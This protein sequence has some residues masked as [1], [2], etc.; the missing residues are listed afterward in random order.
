MTAYDDAVLADN[1][2]GYWVQ[3]ETGGTTLADASGGGHT[4]AITGAPTFAQPGPDG[5]PNAI[6]WPASSSVFAE[7][8]IVGDRYWTFEVWIYLTEY[9]ASNSHLW[10]LGNY[11]GSST[12][13]N[14][15]LHINTD[16]SIFQGFYPDGSVTSPA[17]TISLN[18]WHHL[19]GSAG[20]AGNKIRVDKTTVALGGGDGSDGTSRAIWMHAG[21][22]GGGYA[23]ML[24]AKPAHW[25]SQLSDA[26]TDA[27]YD[28]MFPSVTEATLDYAFPALTGAGEPRAILRDV[29]AAFDID[30]AGSAPLSA[31]LLDYAFP[32]LDIATALD[33]THHT[34]LSNGADLINLTG[35]AEAEVIVP[36][37]PR[38]GHIAAGV[39]Y[40]KAISY[41]AAP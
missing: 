17:G 34:D 9:P 40:D 25:T 8:P 31:G 10:G 22:G 30:M 12:Q 13:E 3:A 24:L 20:P 15:D 35:W 28:A 4:F 37:V 38:P 1:P 21:G 11:R 2:W 39:R 19:V 27:H 16:G 18:T 7:G 41:E 14:A 32:T 23:E 6:L 5:A 26:Q 36:V 29:F 33:N